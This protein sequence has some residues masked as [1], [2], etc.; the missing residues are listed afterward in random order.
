[1]RFKALQILGYVFQIAN[2]EERRKGSAKKVF[3]IESIAYPC[4]LNPIEVKIL[5]EA[6]FRSR[7]FFGREICWLVAPFRDFSLRFEMTGKAYKKIATKS[8][9]IEAE[10]SHP[11]L[12]K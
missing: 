6:S 12:F 2:L 5:F 9:A 10:E 3:S 1:M 11:L 8:G 4:L 7:F